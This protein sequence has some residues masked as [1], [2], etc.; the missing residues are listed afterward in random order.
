MFTPLQAIMLDDPQVLPA[1]RH[2]FSRHP[3]YQEREA[4]ELAAV[5]GASELAVEAALEALT[6]DGEVLP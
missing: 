6:V 5:L 2:L 4:C 3:S 1:L